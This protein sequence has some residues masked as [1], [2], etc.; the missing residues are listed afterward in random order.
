MAEVF[1]VIRALTRHFCVILNEHVR[2]LVVAYGTQLIDR[3]WLSGFVSSKTREEE[4]MMKTGQGG[5]ATFITENLLK[6][7]SEFV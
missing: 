5:H 1:I 6:W 2:R 4:F 7:K 3:M